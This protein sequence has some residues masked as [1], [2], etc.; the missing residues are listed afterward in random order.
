MRDPERIPVILGRL[1]KVWEKNPNL[2]L[3]QL[4]T[5]VFGDAYYIEDE[6][7]V[8]ALESFYKLR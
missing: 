1:R 6:K 4:I 5:N 2:R 3:G 8:E 7:L